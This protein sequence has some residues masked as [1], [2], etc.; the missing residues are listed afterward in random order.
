MAAGHVLATPPKRKARRKASHP[1]AGAIAGATRPSPS[2]PTHAHGA[3]AR[4]F[5]PDPLPVPQETR[6]VLIS[7]LACGDARRLLL[8]EEPPHLHGVLQAALA[9]VGL[10][11]EIL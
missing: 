5:S 4:I 6:N 8:H 9:H 11:Q 1:D 10:V 3:A 2:E 7:I